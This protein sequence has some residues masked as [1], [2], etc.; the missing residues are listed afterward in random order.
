MPWPVP[1]RHASVPVT[2][3]S[4]GE[5]KDAVPGGG[6][7]IPPANPIEA[8]RWLRDLKSSRRCTDRAL[9]ELVGMSKTK[10]QSLLGLLKLAAAVQALVEQEALR[11][12]VAMELRALT[13]GSAQETFAAMAIGQKL[14]ARELASR[15]AHACRKKR[16]SKCSAED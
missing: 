2:S 13:E 8:A 3:P 7:L 9:A 12:T 4:T 15:I 14:T 16:R 1:R 11:P 10:M 5:P 6:P